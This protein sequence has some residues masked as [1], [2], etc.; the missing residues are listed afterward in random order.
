VTSDQK[1]QMLKLVGEHYLSS[2]DFNGITLAEAQQTL[3]I[4][5][6]TTLAVISELATDGLVDLAISG[7]GHVN[8]H[9]KALDLPPWDH[10]HPLMPE[11]DPRDV[12]LYPSPRYLV[13]VVDR[14][15]YV[16]TPFTERLALGEPQLR[17]VAFDLTVLEKYRNDPRYSLWHNDIAGGLTVHDADAASMRNPDRIAIQDFGFC[18]DNDMTRGVAVYLRSLRRLTPEHQQLW[19][20]HC[21]G[22]EYHLHPDYYRSTMLGEFPSGISVFDATLMEM[23]VI[24]EMAIAMRRPPMTYRSRR[25]S[26]S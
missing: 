8:I 4:D 10:L 18:Y 20:A 12:C 7:H 25:A 11:A 14:S 21:L 16:G 24:N 9:I 5:P 15:R 1:E 6:A 13:A 22:G 23:N 26:R 19:F 2:R 17:H 3:G